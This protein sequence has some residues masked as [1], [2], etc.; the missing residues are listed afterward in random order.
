[1]D[2]NLSP[3]QSYYAARADEY[4]A[5]YRK[6]ER[7]SDLR[8]IERW[9]PAALHGRRILELAC[10][11]GHWTRFLAPVASSIVAIDS[12]EE[13]LRIARARVP[14]ANVSF[15]IGDAYVPGRTRGGPFDAAFAGFWFSHVPN[16]RQVEFLAALAA[17][18]EPG[19]KVV[20]LDNLFVEG[21][22]SPLCEKDVLGNTYQS[23]SLGDGSTHRVLKNFP[24]E[25]QLHALVS[26]GLGHSPRYT[27][28]RYYWALEYRVPGHRPER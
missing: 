10:G 26:G 9:L 1:M 2:P 8:E 27:S 4:D 5:I 18:L 21:S 22:S 28:W 17:A 3:L 7:Q 11:T 14:L 25:A 19:A 23:R 13:T 15:A 20:L 6:P 24:S 12:A 16:E